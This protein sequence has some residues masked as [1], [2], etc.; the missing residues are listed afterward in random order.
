MKLRQLYLRPSVHFELIGKTYLCSEILLRYRF[1]LVI[2]G[3]LELLG[4][5]DRF[6]RADLGA[7]PAIDAEPKIKAWL[8]LL[9]VGY[10][11]VRTYLCAEPTAYTLLTVVYGLASEPLRKL[12]LHA[13]ILHC[14]GFAQE[15]FEYVELD[16]RH[17]TTPLL[18][19]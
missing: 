17:F 13:G 19:G 16:A 3:E 6:H 9:I 2:G 5:C 18:S 1:V 11:S 14:R 8:F 10:R 4:H 15:V 12:N 7:S